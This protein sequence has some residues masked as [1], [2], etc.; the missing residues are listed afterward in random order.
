MNELLDDGTFIDSGSTHSA[1]NTAGLAEPAGFERDSSSVSNPASS[2]R[3]DDTDSLHREGT[4]SDAGQVAPLFPADELN[5]FRSHWN[6][7][8]TSFVDEPRSAVEQADNLVATIVQRISEQFANQREELE[9]QWS[10]GEN[11]D[12]EDLRQTLKRY[13]AFFHRLLAF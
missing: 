11:V 6:S 10:R 3:F 9:H 2:S 5:S 13:R 1:H 4:V 12:T 7:V 8:Q